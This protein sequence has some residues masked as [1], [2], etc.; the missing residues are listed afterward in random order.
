MKADQCNIHTIYD[1]AASRRLNDSEETESERR[2]A[3][4][5]TTNDTNLTT[6]ELVKSVS[7]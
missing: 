4:T 5:S 2:F 3:S 1:D 6:T 7:K